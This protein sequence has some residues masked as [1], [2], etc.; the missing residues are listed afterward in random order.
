VFFVGAVLF[1]ATSTHASELPGGDSSSPPSAY[2]RSRTFTTG[3]G[4]ADD[5]IRSL[6]I[7]GPSVWI[8]TDYGL[9]RYDGST[10]T[11][12]TK[13]DGLPDFPVSAIAVDPVTQ[14]VW[15]GSWG[16]GL[17]RF[18]AGRFDRFNQLNSGVSGDVI[19]D[20]AI[21]DGRIWAAT[22]GGISV[23]EP[24]ADDWSLFDGRRLDAPELAVTALLHQGGLLVGNVWR[25]GLRRYT[26]GGGSWLT[27]AVSAGSAG[28]GTFEFAA[29][30]AGGRLWSGSREG[31]TV[32]QRPG[33]GGGML[34]AAH[35]RSLPQG[36]RSG[37]F[38]ECA[39]VADD[40]GL[41]LG[42][43]DGVV[44]LPDARQDVWLHYRGHD[45]GSATVAMWRGGVQVDARSTGAVLPDAGIRCMATCRDCVWLG[46]AKGLVRAT[47]SMSYLSLPT[48][49]AAAHV[50]RPVRLADATN[51][52]SRRPAPGSPDGMPAP[53]PAIA[54]YGP[55]NRTV[56]IPG[57]T[58]R[59]QSP[60][61]RA[62]HWS[63]EL[64][65]E[66]ING[67]GGLSSSELI[68][69]TTVPAGYARYG[70][71]LPEDDIVFFQRAPL[72]VGIVGYMNRDHKIAEAVTYRS[73][74]P[75]MNVAPQAVD[76][77][78][79][80]RVDPWVFRCF[81]NQ[82]R[83]HRMLLDYLIDTLGAERIAA[84][85]TPG[86]DC[87]R[88][89]DWWRD[90]AERRGKPFVV[91]V[92]PDAA[93]GWL[94]RAIETLRASEIDALLTWCDAKTASIIL[95]RLRQAGSDAVFVGGSTL[96]TG[97]LVA[98][99]DVNPGAV[100][101]LLGTDA[102][103]KGNHYGSFAERYSER[104]LARTRGAAPPEEAL[105]SYE[106]TDHMLAAMDAVGC[107]RIAVRGRLRVM[108]RSATGEAH[109]EK[110]HG[111]TRVNIATLKRGVW[112]KSTLESR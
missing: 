81:G 86:G 8:G 64:A 108:D 57:G 55:R 97:G 48:A 88:H 27:D 3:D 105:R 94:D 19:F 23:F 35:E 34:S 11:T 37:G 14:D 100:V 36:L 43:D 41:W 53:R 79:V 83:E 72:V 95:T 2:T 31:V 52:A 42:M 51:A 47:D 44:V 33:A 69:A 39:A 45:G 93:S 89:L 84:L 1:G 30:D 12:W 82:P 62:D 29:I 49:P 112:V 87:A 21:V 46:T 32:W 106:A 74:V 76:P 26:E 80:E 70:W 54:V 40:G 66:R 109:Y 77:V 16:G 10:L 38:V 61:P 15:L 73:D 111:P 90:Q 28:V 20:V 85:R 92:L 101:A 58:Q 56:R 98:M 65:I 68:H 13:V 96:M 60:P 110:L 102:A 75:W 59:D 50:D 99:V 6:C 25:T 24:F 104:A 63:V 107:D 67:L 71:T 17:V 103:D 5:S 78:S 7:D 4:L 18:T 91:D 22:D 9:S